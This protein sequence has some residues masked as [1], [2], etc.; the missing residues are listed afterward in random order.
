MARERAK[1]MDQRP[2]WM[3]CTVGTARKLASAAHGFPGTRQN[4][5]L[6]N[7]ASVYLGN[8]C[9]DGAVG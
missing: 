5:S 7:D 2:L 3:S 1:L 8:V 6:P 9:V 4:D